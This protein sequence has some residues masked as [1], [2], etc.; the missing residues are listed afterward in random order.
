MDKD[1]LESHH[2]DV[3]GNLHR[4]NAPT[5]PSRHM[6]KIEAARK[7]RPLQVALLGFASQHWNLSSK[8]L[9]R[10]YGVANSFQP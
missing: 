3:T 5:G 10:T 6:L 4:D 7:I 2:P 1:L 9:D 8:S